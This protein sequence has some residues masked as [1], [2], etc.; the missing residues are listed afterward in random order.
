MSIRLSRTREPAY[1]AAGRKKQ[2]SGRGAPVR[3]SHSWSDISPSPF[4]SGSG[5]Y[6]DSG[7]LLGLD[8]TLGSA[9]ELNMAGERSAGALALRSACTDSATRCTRSASSHGEIEG[10]ATPATWLRAV[11]TSAGKSGTLFWSGESAED[12]ARAGHAARLRTAAADPR[13]TWTRLRCMGAVVSVAGGRERQEAWIGDVVV[14]GTGRVGRACGDASRLGRAASLERSL[15][16]P[17]RTQ[18]THTKL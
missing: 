10:F 12:R 8:L 2:G 4:C 16:T 15:S 3:I 7:P 14:G 11:C 1:R 17:N 13:C 9:G 6:C 5:S 18:H